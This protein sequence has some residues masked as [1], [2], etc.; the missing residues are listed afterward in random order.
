MKKI[1]KAQLFLQ[2]HLDVFQCPVCHSPFKEITDFQLSCQENHHFDLSKKGTLH[3]LLKLVQSDYTKEMLLSRQRIAHSGF[4]YPMLDE[5]FKQ[6]KTTEGVHLDVGCGEGAHSHYLKTRGL[7]GPTIAFDISK[8]GIQLGAATYDD[9]FF[10]VADLAQSPFSEQSFDTIINILSPSNY[11]EFKRL[12]KPGGQVIKVVPG[13]NYL[14]ELRE[15]S[16]KDS[17]EYSNTEVIRKFAEVFPDYTHIPVHYT[18]TLEDDEIR[19]FI[20]MTP[21]GWHAEWNENMK[22]QL[23]RITIDM[24]IL[25]GQTSHW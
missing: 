13:K 15:V 11:K 14:K 16:R 21:L 1:E 20:Q 2:N 24:V 12:L 7:S 23:K 18:H 22:K 8:E 3:F 10:L 4:W 19:D 6:I 17:R 5:V 9:L 25:V